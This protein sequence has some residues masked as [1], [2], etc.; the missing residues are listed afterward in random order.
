MPQS[1]TSSKSP[2]DANLLHAICK[3]CPVVWLHEDEKYMPTSWSFLLDNGIMKTE[4]TPYATQGS[5][6]IGKRLK[7]E[8]SGTEDS[9]L[10]SKKESPKLLLDIGNFQSCTG[11]S[12][13]PDPDNTL[14]GGFNHDSPP[15]IT[16]YTAGVL[17]NKDGISFC[18]VI[19]AP[20]YAWNGTVEYHAFDIEQITIRFQYTPTKSKDSI[21]TKIQDSSI[22]QSQGETDMFDKWVVVR[23]LGSVHGNFM[24]YGTDFVGGDDIKVKFTTADSN[25]G[26]DAGRVVFYSSVES[27]AMY[28]TAG[29]QKRILGFG[30]DYTGEGT[31]WAPS[32]V[33][34]FVIDETS[35]RF[36]IVLDVKNSTV[37]DE[38]PNHFLMGLYCG[39]IGNSENNQSLVPFKSG[40]INLI[41]AGDAYLK[42]TEKGGAINY[43]FPTEKKKDKFFKLGIAGVSVTLF[44]Q[45]LATILVLRYITKL[46][47]KDGE[48]HSTVKTVLAGTGVLSGNT[49]LTLLCSASVVI[50]VLL[51]TSSNKAFIKKVPQ[52][53]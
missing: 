11:Y 48:S 4:G 31:L 13:P 7:D 3:H 47:K 40:V 24:W 49:L 12:G 43:A 28:P 36:P 51:L 18:D 37:V 30:N 41:S 10:T 6:K 34:L 33:S 23:V 44:L 14:Y 16:A 19:Y 53:C 26:I 5:T 8:L 15:A 39:R 17:T 32:T 25:P 1:S 38:Y 45:I 9:V 52:Q 29:V 21:Y 22:I 27:H 42:F 35:S 20:Q 50:V 46:K 2:L